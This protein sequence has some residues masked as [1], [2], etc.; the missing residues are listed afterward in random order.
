MM[1]TALVSQMAAMPLLEQAEVWVSAG[2]ELKQFPR[3]SKP[4]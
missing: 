2:L 4:F 3:G 1:R